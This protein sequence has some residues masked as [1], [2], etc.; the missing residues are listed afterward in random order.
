[1][2]ETRIRVVDPMSLRDLP[3][4]QQGLLLAS[5]PGVMRGYYKDA[6]S[7]RQAMR[8]GPGWFDTGDLGWRAPGE[9]SRLT[10]GR[11]HQWQKGHFAYL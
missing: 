4:G 7:T 11:T 8:A 2:P 6:E 1:M 5:G 9:C 3:E 10:S